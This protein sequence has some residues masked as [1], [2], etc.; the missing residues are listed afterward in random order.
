MSSTSARAVYV[1]LFV[2]VALAVF[3]GAIL[4]VGTLQNAFTSKI[5]VHAVFE[6]VG[7]LQ[8]GDSVWSSGVRVGTIAGIAFVEASK[9]DVTLALNESAVPFIPA[10]VEATIGSDGLIGNPIV[11]LNGGT[12]GGPAIQ[13]GAQLAIGESVST[14]D[15]FATLQENNENLLAITDD[16]KTITGRLRDGEGTIGRLLTEDDLL[17]QVQSALADIEAASANAKELTASLA[18]FSAE[19]QRPGQLPHDLV[20]D[21]EILPSVKASV[22]SLQAVADRAETLVD[23]VST[24]LSDPSTPV[25]SLLGDREMGS[26]LGGTV[27]NLEDATELLKEDLRALQSNFLFRPYFKK[28]EREEKKAQ[29]KAEREARRE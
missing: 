4:A 10:D 26:D 9:V 14:E 7:G 28:Q 21:D 23:D 13:A 8:A 5:E 22:A 12:R 1:G 16:I 25:G 11:Q 20:T 24:K 17:E 6:E 27:A 29:R 15:L 2:A 3:A 19:L 18:R